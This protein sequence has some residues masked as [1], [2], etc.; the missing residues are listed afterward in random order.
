LLTAILI[1][2]LGV[3][4]HQN[5]VFEVP[6]FLCVIPL[7]GVGPETKFAIQSENINKLEQ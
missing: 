7:C 3:E 4:D 6:I 1:G 2:R 5:G